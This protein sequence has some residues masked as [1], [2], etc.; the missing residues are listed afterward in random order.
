[1]VG[2][3]ILL[4]AVQRTI[5]PLRGFGVFSDGHKS[6]ELLTLCL[7]VGFLLR[8]LVKPPQQNLWVNTGS[9]NRPST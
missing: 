9:G 5:G 8:C 3:M 2:P 6:L 1:M 4:H 7:E